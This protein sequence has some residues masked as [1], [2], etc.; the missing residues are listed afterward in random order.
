M[1]TEDACGRCGSG[2]R[3]RGANM[4][5]ALKWNVGVARGKT[6]S[7]RLRLRPPAPRRAELLLLPTLGERAALPMRFTRPATFA[8]RRLWRLF[9]LLRDG[10][11]E[12]GEGGGEGNASGGGSGGSG[13][14]VQACAHWC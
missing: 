9:L 5:S 11:R 10:A 4:S 13:G 12:D 6:G 8:R 7:A 3:P 14:D 2:G 1:I